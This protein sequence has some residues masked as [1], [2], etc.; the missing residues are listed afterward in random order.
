MNTLIHNK[1]RIAD[2]QCEDEVAICDARYV[3][4]NVMRG[5]MGRVLLLNQVVGSSQCGV[6]GLR[7]A[8]KAILPDLLSIESET[9][10]HRELAVWAGFHHPNI[11]NLNEIL[12]AGSDGQIAAM[13]G[14]V[15]SLRDCLKNNRSLSL[16]VATNV[17]D[18]ITSGLSYAYERDE[19][20]HLDIKPENVLYNWDV[21]KMMKP[22][23]Q[24]DIEKW[25]FMVSDWGI[26]SIKNAQLNEVIDLPQDHSMRLKTFNNLGTCLYMAPERFMKGKKSSLAS[27][28]FSLGLIYLELLVGYL[29][30]TFQKSPVDELLS[31]TYYSNADLI[32]KQSSI[33]ESI[34]GFILKCIS[35]QQE[36][37]PLS[38]TQLRDSLATAYHSTKDSSSRLS[39]V[40]VGEAELGLENPLIRESLLDYKMEYADKQAN[41]LRAVGR[42]NE[43]AEV[44]KRHLD[45]VLTE[46]QRDPSNPKEPLIKRSFHAGSS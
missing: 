8:L 26:A 28:I 36:E 39:P 2:L 5:G 42:N 37:R 7:I 46:Y 38:Y 29:P 16:K 25:R 43:A 14:C 11:V 15:G 13:P 23:E 19:V 20:L 18:D 1:L 31:G 27:D 6:H 4:K 41:N 21:G 33:P 35:R 3:V 30:Y 17:I 24:S 12:D 10:F 45:D 32:L 40:S 34:A 22:G 9:L 44:L